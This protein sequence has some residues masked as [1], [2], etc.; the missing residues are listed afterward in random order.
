MPNLVTKLLCQN[1]R[2]TLAYKEARQQ[3]WAAKSIVESVS[4]ITIVQDIGVNNYLYI[5]C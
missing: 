5:L 2:N 3:I 4:K 1:L